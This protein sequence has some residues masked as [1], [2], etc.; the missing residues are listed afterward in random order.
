MKIR[1]RINLGFVTLVVMVLVTGV[2]GQYAIDR[3]VERFEAIADRL[4]PGL[5]ELGEVEGEIHRII[6]ESVS[7]ALLYNVD[8]DGVL[9]REIADDVAEEA[10]ELQEA[11]NELEERVNRVGAP[12]S[13]PLFP[14]EERRLRAELAELHVASNELIQIAQSGNAR[15]DAGELAELKERME[16][17]EGSLER[18]LREAASRQ[19][20]ILE[21]ERRAARSFANWTALFNLAVAGVSLGFVVYFAVLL[22]RKIT[23]PLARI[24]AATRHGGAGASDLLNI[25]ALPESA[26]D[27]IGELSDALREMNRRLRDSTVS[28]D[29]INAILESMSDMLFVLDGEWRVVTV[30]RALCTTLGKSEEEL[31]GL[32]FLNG[33]IAEDSFDAFDAFDAFGAGPASGAEQSEDSRGSGPISAALLEASESSAQGE[34]LPVTRRIQLI[35]AGG[36]RVP[37]AFAAAALRAGRTGGMV[38]VARDIR[39]DLAREAELTEARERAEAGSRSKS[40][41][42]MNLSH[43]I[44]TPL[45]S[46]V[47]LAALLEETV[48]D[49]EQSEHV[50]SLA[51]ASNALLHLINNFLD[52]SRVESGRVEPHP[53][54]V[55]PRE[56]VE[57]LH[58][59]YKPQA[60]AGGLALNTSV[61]ADVPRR[62]L[63]DVDL[64]NQILGNLIGNAIKFTSQGSVDLSVSVEASAPGQEIQNELPPHAMQMRFVIQDSGPGVPA[65]KRELIFEAF[66]QAD[67]SITRKFGGTGLGL[68]ISK[69]L[70]SILGGS[71]ALDSPPPTN[72]SQDGGARFVVSI[73]VEPISEAAAGA[74]SSVSPT[75][76]AFQREAASTA[77]AIGDVRVL[78]VEDN[79]NNQML[80]RAFLKRTAARLEI[81]TDGRAAM[82]L[83]EPLFANGSS[84][85]GDGAR[86]LPYDLI[87]MDMQMPVMDGYTT[88]RAIREREER[89]G[90]KRVPIVAL[91][92][93]ALDDARAQSFAC[94]CD[95]HV[96]KPIGKQALLELIAR[97]AL[98]PRE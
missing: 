48:L 12:G 38:C 58:G 22:N 97:F 79:E 17:L 35:S 25:E 32:S 90:F 72:S 95:E 60:V 21:E 18:L 2:A 51:T 31:I 10:S 59:I 83:L 8:S 93:H 4:A 69:R 14:E 56:L 42:L 40:E 16:D 1:D 20:G 77:P 75:G 71:I 62:V 53:V 30:N 65:E 43:E 80:V 29:Y 76:G 50:R 91:T 82:D 73:P 15:R 85:N 7:I 49:S 74:R 64:L 19:S 84:A 89:A 37:V 88:T 13:M 70:T 63:V 3:N 41:F 36:E 87:L 67:N 45:H 34:R 28:R 26:G 86:G 78:L 94:G 23:L 57:N 5:R 44:R 11:W 55:Q 68:A 39:E 47:G 81:A 98:S 92:A 33:S 96:V 66:E 54:L 27:E 52:L 6:S 24:Q 46:V 61:D 9:T